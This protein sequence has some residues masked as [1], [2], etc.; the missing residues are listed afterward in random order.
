MRLWFEEDNV[1]EFRLNQERSERGIPAQGKLV[2]NA[3]L[4]GTPRLLW[5]AEFTRTK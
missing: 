2:P 4:Y 1:L 3:G 5:L